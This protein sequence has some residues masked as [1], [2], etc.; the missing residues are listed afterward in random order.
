MFSTLDDVAGKIWDAGE[1]K[2]AEVEV[3]VLAF[4]DLKRKGENGGIRNAI[5]LWV[6]QVISDATDHG[7]KRI[8]ELALLLEERNLRI[9]MRG[10]YIKPIIISTM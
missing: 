4:L 8:E 3:I 5:I 9:G 2:K 6:D 1:R 7:W 10:I